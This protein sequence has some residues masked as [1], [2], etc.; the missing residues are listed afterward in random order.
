MHAELLLVS[1]LVVRDPSSISSFTLIC[2]Q[3]KS[4]VLGCMS[5][6]CNWWSKGLICRQL[7]YVFLPDI[8]ATRCP[9]C[10]G[11]QQLWEECNS[12]CAK[13]FQDTSSEFCLVFP[14]SVGLG[15]LMVR[16]TK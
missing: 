3:L 8:M 5:S 15:E 4:S 1:A 16:V 6:T 10:S 12:L 2:V 7:A 13:A 14:C 11:K 9:P